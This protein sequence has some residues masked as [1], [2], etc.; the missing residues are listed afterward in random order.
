MTTDTQ[1]AAQ[2]S[3]E[4]LAMLRKLYERSKRADSHLDDQAARDA[5]E[6]EAAQAAEM[7]GRLLD[8][9]GLALADVDRAGHSQQISHQHVGERTLDLGKSA[10]NWKKDLAKAVAKYNMVQVLGETKT[11][12]AFVGLALHVE[13]TMMMLEWLY[14][15]IKSIA[16]ADYRQW[17]ATNSWDHIDP[18]R[19]HTSFGKGAT[20]RLSGRLWQVREDQ[21]MAEV[22]RARETAGEGQVTGLAL[23][24]GTAVRDYLE[25]KHP[26]RKEARLANEAYNARVEARRRIERARAK[27]LPIWF[28]HQPP[29]VQLA[30]IV[31]AGK[32]KAAD[33]E[34]WENYQK[35]NAAKAAQRERYEEKYERKHG[36]RPGEGRRRKEPVDNTNYDAYDAGYERADSINL[37]PHLNAGE[38]REP[39]ALGS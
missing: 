23:N 2:I 21:R 36:H 3:D 19:W 6:R 8:K 28:G 4:T 33:D 12:I 17:K 27:A 38:Q 29:V 39:A 32:A 10:F 26:W 22:A 13:S 24:I 25:E 31:A 1:T 30:L 9:Y 20:E 37:T 7:L 5:A 16:A 11:T 35:E 18:L 15:Q 34:W 14:A